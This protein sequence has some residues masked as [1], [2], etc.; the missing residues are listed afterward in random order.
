MNILSV[1]VRKCYCVQTKIKSLNLLKYLNIITLL[2]F[3]FLNTAFAQT[4]FFG[5][6]ETEGDRMSF[7][8]S[9]YSFGYHKL[10]VDFEKERAD[11]III[12]GNINWRKYHGKT[13]WNVLDFI[14]RALWESDFPEGEY[15]IT[16]GDTVFLDNIYARKSFRFMDITVGRQPISLGT[17]YAWNP[18]D[19]FNRKDL[20]DPTYEQP[21][22]GALRVEVP[23]GDRMGLDLI[24]VSDSDST[25]QTKMIQ[26][27]AGKGRFDYTLN[28]A[29]QYHLFPYWRT[30]DSLKTHDTFKFIGGSFVGQIGEV[31]LWGEWLYSK[32][33]YASFVEWV[34]GADHTF[35]NGLY[36]MGEFFHNGLGAKDNELGFNHFA[37][38]L[39]GET[40][41][42]MQNYM[43]IGMNYRFTDFISGGMFAF[44]NVDDGSFSFVPQ[45]EWSLEEDVS[46][47]LIFSKNIGGA[48][49]EYG[50]QDTAI[51]L[52]LRAYF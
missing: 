28:V 1:M 10:R 19:I 47:S 45:V 16:I 17:G 24:L 3:L 44:G 32:N 41:S 22:V 48:N 50:V 25:D 26:F 5:Y 6:F 15:F 42:L 37:H 8:N 9:Q 2:T 43:F 13:T 18:L 12:A 36:I 49:S 46:L 23:I 34:F 4:D 35:E 52:K 40:H 14:P 31:G 21:G 11:G 38:F 27:K 51:R 33:A 29:E 30:A 7:A 20:M 39:G